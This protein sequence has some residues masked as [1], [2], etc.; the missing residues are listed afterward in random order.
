MHTGN[1]IVFCSCIYAYVHEETTIGFCVRISGRKYLNWCTPFS[2]VSQWNGFIYESMSEIVN[3]RPIY[4]KWPKWPAYGSFQIPRK[5]WFL[6]GNALSFT[7]LEFSDDLNCL[8]S[9]DN[10]FPTLFIHF[11]SLRIDWVC[12]FMVTL[13]YMTM[14]GN[15]AFRGA[16]HL[17][18]A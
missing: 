4:G 9:K 16:C 5:K 8:D 3:R 11:L 18:P 17:G 2:D 6:G 14:S 15:K 10:Q 1:P 7:F 13:L 12:V